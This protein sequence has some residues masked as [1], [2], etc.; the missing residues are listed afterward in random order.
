MRTVHAIIVTANNSGHWV[1]Y[2]KKENRIS[3]SM[4]Q[5]Y[6]ERHELMHVIDLLDESRH[7]VYTVIKYTVD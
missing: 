3:L 6:I 1:N 2:D 5:Q 7:M 4:N